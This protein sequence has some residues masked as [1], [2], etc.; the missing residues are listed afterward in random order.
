MSRDMQTYPAGLIALLQL[1]DSSALKLSDDVV[2]SV[3]AFDFF[4][5]S[6]Y[7]RTSSSTA[8][9]VDGGQNTVSLRVPEGQTWF[10]YGISGELAAGEAGDELCCEMYVSIANASAY[11]IGQTEVLTAVAAG[12][13]AL[14]THTYERPVVL[15]AGDGFLLQGIVQNYATAPSGVG[16][17][18][19]FFSRFGPE[20]TSISV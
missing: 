17:I 4:A 1:K 15:R 6:R 11:N 20:S 9:F 10:V 3:E 16:T 14:V 18:R 7:A 8:T 12:Q 5:A 2:A 19:C 13:R